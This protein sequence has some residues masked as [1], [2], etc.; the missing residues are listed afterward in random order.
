ML[1]RNIH[2]CV[3]QTAIFL[4]GAFACLLFYI[5]YIQVIDAEALNT[6]PLN[7]RGLVL[8]AEVQRGKI[9]DAHGKSLAVSSASGD[10]TYPYSAAAAAVTGYIGER[11]GGAGI[12]GIANRELLGEAGE[13]TRLGPIGQLFSSP[14]G[15]DVKLT[16]DAGVQQ[17]AYD[18]LGSRR[19]A[20][21]VLDA[22][23]GAVLA[24]VS[25]PSFSPA[26]AEEDWDELRQRADS[27][28]LNRALSGLYPPGSTI[29]P[30]IA[31]AAL[32]EKATDLQE[33]F[34][35]TGQL[36]LGNGYT[37]AES[38][39]EVHGKVNLEQALTESCNVTFGTLAMRLGDAKL[40]KAFDRFGFTKA[41]TGDVASAAPH[42][43]DFSR[44]GKGDT[45]QIGIGQSELL[46]TPISMA[47]LAAAFANQGVIM[48]PYMIDEVITPNGVVLRKTEPTK[49][50][51]ADT[52][53]R[54]QLINRF[55]EQVVLKGTGT[56][57]AVSG[58]RVTG[59]TGTAENSSGAD[60]AWFIGSAELPNRRI[61]FAIIVEN[62]GG[63]GTE[64]API[65]RS[66]IRSLLDI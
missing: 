30:L 23:T 53:E 55:M 27:P 18:A 8:A 29:K 44:L 33:V 6:N 45:A 35:C 3:L 5:M 61:A 25:R 9:L 66:I 20:V 38:H 13:F 2:K 51:E 58:I 17:A 60:H 43:P 54:A 26:S 21:V 39:G 46:V 63:G 28:L 37:I 31:D 1:R 47:M 59:K 12:E 11:I 15:N 42:L 32:A 24:M 22:G 65:A 57:A 14:R 64:A 34:N 62:S 36:D 56:A 49:W 50:L 40:Q 10:R 7:R 48:K 4:F 19:G 52:T 16:I 41:L